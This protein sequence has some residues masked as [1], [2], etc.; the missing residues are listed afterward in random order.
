MEERYRSFQIAYRTVAPNAASITIAVLAIKARAINGAGTPVV[1]ASRLL[2]R[3]SRLIV[4]A[5]TI[6][7]VGILKNDG[8]IF[9]LVTKT[10][11]KCSVGYTCLQ[12]CKY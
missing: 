3:I 4:R 5:V 7:I 11:G 10:G 6:K 1:V 8:L 2:V 9:M 12:R